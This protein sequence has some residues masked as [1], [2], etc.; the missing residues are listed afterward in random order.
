MSVISMCNKMCFSVSL[1]KPC[2]K[3]IPPKILMALLH[4]KVGRM[5][6]KYLTDC[7]I[8]TSLTRQ[9]PGLVLSEDRRIFPARSLLPSPAPTAH[10]TEQRP[11][12]TPPGAQPVVFL[13]RSISWLSPQ[14]KLYGP[15]ILLV[16]AS[17][18]PC[19]ATL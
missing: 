4:R 7:G 17:E 11:R 10:L 5:P 15:Y 1:R 6:S 8:S 13:C 3:T 2:N 14:S 16:L 12:Q 9:F 19:T 18:A